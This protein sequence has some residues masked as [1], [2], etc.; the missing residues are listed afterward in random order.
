MAELYQSLGKG[1]RAILHKYISYWK[2]W[3]KKNY[4]LDVLQ[5]NW[6]SYCF[7][8]DWEVTTLIFLALHSRPKQRSILS[9]P[10]G[11]EAE[12]PAEGSLS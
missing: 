8:V 10:N 7:Y 1:K 2:M 12:T 5:G 3:C 11:N 4:V 9:L 6:V